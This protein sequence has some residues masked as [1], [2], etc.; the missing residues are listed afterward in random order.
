MNSS[1]GKT[2]SSYGLLLVG[3]AHTHQENY[4][5]AFAADTRCHLIGMV[6]EADIPVRRRELNQQ[7]AD[8]LNIPVLEDLIQAINRDD[9]DIVSVCVEPERR[10]RVAML[11]AQSGKQAMQTTSI[12]TLI[13]SASEGSG[14]AFV[15]QH[16][17]NMH[18]CHWTS[19][20]L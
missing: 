18:F 1:F 16:A 4:A 11:V 9:V 2:E 20:M 7:L 12:S 15:R 17:D 10:A 19:R 3:G 13:E 6:D 8:E 5:P 14:G